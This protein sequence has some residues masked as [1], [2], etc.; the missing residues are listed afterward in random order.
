MTSE[1]WKEVKEILDDLL[2]LTP[3]E[4]PARLQELSQDH[5]IRREVESLLEGESTSSSMLEQPLF[6]IS[7]E[8]A[9]S[10]I[11]RRIGVYRL[12]RLLGRGGMGSVY[13]ARREDD[14]N[15][16]VTVKLMNPDMYYQQIVDRFLN[17]RQILAQLQHPNIAHILDGGT[18]EDNFP[19]IVMEY[20]DG[21]RID[22]YCE[23]HKLG[24]DQRLKL[25]RD[26]CSAVHFAHQNLVVHR[27][28]KPGN[29]LVTSQGVPK[30]LDFGI[31]KIMDVPEG[32][33]AAKMLDNLSGNETSGRR[34]M[35]LNYASPEQVMGDAITTASD[36]YSLGVLLYGLLSLQYPYELSG[37]SQEKIVR[38]ICHE[39]PNKPSQAIVDW[40]PSL[41]TRAFTTEAAPEQINMKRLSR[42][43]AGDLDAI[44]L[45]AMAKLIKERYNSA[46][47]L[48]ED[49]GRH[50]THQPI[51]GR[52]ST[53]SY[54]FEKFVRRNK[55]IVAIIALVSAAAIAIFFLWQQA[56]I[57]RGQMEQERDRAEAVTKFIEDI[58]EEA[59]PDNT[60]GNEVSVLEILHKGRADIDQLSTEPTTQARVLR[61]MGRI[62]QLLGNYDIAKEIREEAV[63]IQRI[64]APDSAELATDLANLALVYRSLGQYDV[65]ERGLREALKIRKKTVKDPLVTSLTQYNL[66]NVLTNSGNYEEARELHRLSLST[67]IQLAPES[68]L[69]GSSYYAIG[70]VDYALGRFE[71][72][73]TNLRNAMVIYNNLEK[74]SIERVASLEGYLGLVLLEMNRLQDAES[75]LRSSLET[76]RK[77]L[78]PAHKKVATAS[79]RLAD[80]LLRQ[81]EIAEAGELLKEAIP[82]LHTTLQNKNSWER[83]NGDAV[84]GSYWV[85]LGQYEEAEGLLLHGYQ[86]SRVVKTEESTQTRIAKRRLHALYT[87]WGQPEKAAPYT[88]ENYLTI[89]KAQPSS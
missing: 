54:R 79:I 14:F 20:V 15:Y 35:T 65:A 40:N 52:R 87:A 82:T 38:T 83:A 75:Y 27:D 47:Q 23:R 31:A 32:S 17:E 73:E 22:T 60:Q 81:G 55:L 4:R 51:L 78:G 9:N 11:G 16:V 58:F 70:V 33:D 36:V 19:Y 72:S 59:K 26:V 3:A 25:F 41:A 7:P 71:E 10:N 42:R 53:W 57:A 85:A 56:E 76:R 12:E 84:L 67:R 63:R 66:A 30:L 13:L 21:E 62:Y 77:I 88:D 74:A 44:V 49:L 43:L 24:V 45:K 64:Y 39:D 48:S 61:S 86:L 6:S 18:T 69:V 28:I 80:L 29:I 34:P 68:G 89:P 5:E 8:E 2:D 50:L 46:E 1:Q 37:A